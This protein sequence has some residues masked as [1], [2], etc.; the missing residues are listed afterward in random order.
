M[1]SVRGLKNSNATI[2]HS[3]LGS[4]ATSPA[5]LSLTPPH[6]HRRPRPQTMHSRALKSVIPL[7]AIRGP[8]GPD[9]A[10][11]PAAV[12]AAASLAAAAADP[13]VAAANPAAA[14]AAA[15]AL[16]G[17]SDPDAIIG[18]P[19]FLSAPIASLGPNTTNATNATNATARAA[20]ARPPPLTILTVPGTNV[21]GARAAAF[22]PREC[23]RRPPPGLAGVIS[24]CVG[25]SCYLHHVRRGHCP[26]DPGS[27][28]SV[29]IA[30]FRPSALPVAA[31][32]W[33][34]RP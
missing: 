25:C 16:Y 14:A 7:A 20:A 34:R 6:S 32:Q 1:A 22:Q 26:R 13:S 3:H 8:A 5:M 15:A 10:P 2:N 11:S 30:D 31:A 12:A 9:D 24:A 33:V 19:E 18:T 4:P 29:R 17:P 27:I 21:S 23:T 28:C